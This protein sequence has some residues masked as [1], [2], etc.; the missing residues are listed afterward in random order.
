MSGLFLPLVDVL[1]LLLF[2]ALFLE[3]LLLLIM[4]SLHQLE[5]HHSIVLSCLGLITPL[6]MGLGGV[7]LPGAISL[8]SNSGYLFLEHLTHQQ[9]KFGNKFL[10]LC[11]KVKMPGVCWFL[12]IFKPLIVGLS[13]LWVKNISLSIFILQKSLGT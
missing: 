13:G 1:F 6:W 9:V 4:S 11:T 8:I 2:L 7:L 10:M 5:Y 12:T 3:T